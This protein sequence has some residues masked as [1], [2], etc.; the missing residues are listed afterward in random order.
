MTEGQPDLIGRLDHRLS[1][2]TISVIKRGSVVMS[3][4]F[5][6]FVVVVV[7]VVVVVERGKP[8]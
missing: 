4:M 7:L 3:A 1:T 2:R 5:D 6:L 8:R